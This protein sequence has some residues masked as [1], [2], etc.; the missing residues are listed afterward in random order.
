MWSPRDLEARFGRAK[1]TTQ[2]DHVDI[3][4]KI[5]LKIHGGLKTEGLDEGVDMERKVE[6]ASI[7]GGEKKGF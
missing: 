1:K 2:V 3:N 7:G 6:E 4:S 5:D